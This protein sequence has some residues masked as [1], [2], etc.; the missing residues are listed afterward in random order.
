[1]FRTI[2]SVAVIANAAIFVKDGF[3]GASVF[4][5]CN[6]VNERQQSQSKSPSERFEFESITSDTLIQPVFFPYA[7]DS[8]APIQAQQPFV[9]QSAVYIIQ[10]D[11]VVVNKN[12]KRH[13]RPLRITNKLAPTHA[14]PM[15]ASPL[16]AT[17][18]QS[19]TFPV[20][21]KQPS[22]TIMQ[23]RPNSPQYHLSQRWTDLISSNNAYP[24]LV[25]S[26]EHEQSLRAPTGSV[27]PFGLSN[28]IVQPHGRPL[29]AKPAY[30]QDLSSQPVL[31]FSTLLDQGQSTIFGS[32]QPSPHSRPVILKEP[33][34]GQLLRNLK[35]LVDMRNQPI[36]STRGLGQNEAQ[37]SGYEVFSQP[38]Q[39]ATS[40][41]QQ[42]PYQIASTRYPNEKRLV[43]SKPRRP[44][45]V[46][47]TIPG[48]GVVSADELAFLK[49]LAQLQ[50]FDKTGKYPMQEDLAEKFYS[51]KSGSPKQVE[52]KQEAQRPI[53]VETLV[54]RLMLNSRVA[55]FQAARNGKHPSLLAEEPITA[56]DTGPDDETL[57]PIVEGVNPVQEEEDDDDDD[58]YFS[59]DD[60]DAAS[61]ES[62][63]DYVVTRAPIDIIQNTTSA[64]SVF[65]NGSLL[66][67]SSP[68]ESNSTD[69]WR[70]LT[71][72]STNQLSEVEKSDDE[73]AEAADRRNRK[74]IRRERTREDDSG[75]V[76]G[77]R[78]I[79]R[80]DLIR[81][82]SIV[83]KMGNDKSKSSKERRKIKRLLRFL[84]RVALENF[85][86]DQL[87]RQKMKA[88]SESDQRSKQQREPLR[89][90]LSSP[91]DEVPEVRQS[92]VTQGQEDAIKLMLSS[93]P[94]KNKYAEDESSDGGAERGGEKEVNKPEAK[95][96]GASEKA[97]K[98]LSNLSRDLERYLDK[99]FF[100]EL[101]ERVE[102]AGDNFSRT[103]EIRDNF[104]KEPQTDLSDRPT[105]KPGF[106]FKTASDNHALEEK[107]SKLTNASNRK[108]ARRLARPTEKP[109]Q[110]DQQRKRKKLPS[111]ESSP[112]QMR[113]PKGRPRQEQR[114]QVEKDEDEEDREDNS[115]RSFPSES[116]DKITN[117]TST[118]PLSKSSP[119]RGASKRR[120]LVE[121]DRT[122]SGNSS[123]ATEDSV[124]D[125]EN[126]DTRESTD[127]R[128][129]P[130]PNDASDSASQGGRKKIKIA[131]QAENSE[132]EEVASPKNRQ[133]EPSERDDA[134]IKPIRP[135]T[136]SKNKRRR[137]NRR[138][139]LK[140]PSN[141]QVGN[142]KHRTL[143]DHESRY[144]IPAPI[145][146]NDRHVTQPTSSKDRKKQNR[147]SVK[148]QRVEQTADKSSKTEDV[149][150][151]HA[152]RENRTHKSKDSRRPPSNGD[153]VDSDE[154]ID[155]SDQ[156]SPNAEQS[157]GEP[158]AHLVE[159]TS[160]SGVCEDDGS[161]QVTL[162][163]NNPKL[164][165]AIK[166]RD[167]PGIARH[168]NK[169]MG[170]E[171]EQD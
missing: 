130:E 166:A 112:K 69:V 117:A 104:D 29:G 19:P 23:I 36:S 74:R 101:G 120:K 108:A 79:S 106:E 122:R 82:I 10:R 146:T 157:D 57:D 86:H 80:L 31:N 47:Q 11:A 38:D 73:T 142:A 133:A 62:S 64:L 100:D 162:K 118:N 51:N 72:L 127:D 163:S 113:I 165:R 158:V 107:S 103:D 121:E 126:E 24:T 7:T 151:S 77:D 161:C 171:D 67:K 89:S 124:D 25:P 149:S 129:P 43:V 40:V 119:A 33:E 17:L 132:P 110:L 83:S 22:R 45:V 98:K 26:I 114:K 32:G 111:Q 141:K 159:G 136:T 55:G 30:V 164:G 138:R 160:Y 128:K 6:E 53:P 102:S 148:R 42:V 8:F 155:E 1:M 84:V 91:K 13:R 18:A 96:Q 90:L 135:S 87:S 59:E 137:D 60:N 116:E 143:K 131:D 152:D 27:A 39:P 167:E 154:D 169:W 81:L 48:D 125:A 168:L 66:F 5:S 63:P 70:P 147:T 97:R 3:F 99:D 94:R 134:Q 4:V 21:P 28:G 144:E 46:G 75:L 61:A 20:P 37:H 115:E 76:I 50:A 44:K 93:S 88:F 15:L 92:S 71:T 12:R 14:M 16:I 153:D 56:N 58:E 170:D 78:P 105:E 150:N 49:S 95:N 156:S 41:R 52:A 35:P 68:L 54:D 2:L 140:N 109:E 145:L 139:V 85:K 9:P 123:Y 65:N 34:V